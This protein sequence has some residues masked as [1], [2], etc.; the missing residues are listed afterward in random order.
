MNRQR[1]TG[2]EARAESATEMLRK[3]APVSAT[4]RARWGAVIIVLAPAVLCA[5]FVY[6]PH[7]HGALPNNEAVAE[8][9]TADPTRWAVAHLGIGVGSGLLILA[10]IAIRSYLREA[11]EE[12]W[13]AVALPFIVIGSTLYALLPAMEF[14]PLAAVE[15]GADAAAAQGALGPWFLPILLTGAAFF[16]VGAAGFAAAIARSGVLGPRLTW[17]VASMLVV[18]AAARFI[19]LS[20]VQL[21]VQGVAGVLALWPLA[22]V[23]WR[24]AAVRPAGLPESSPAI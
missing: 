19:P 18:M 14:A 23:M 22:Y 20:V 1:F 24:H 13:S 2:D 8:A 17:L 6:H 21:Y 7:L 5:A 15:I 11:G 9:V 10:F 3:D 16:A 4:T 12:R